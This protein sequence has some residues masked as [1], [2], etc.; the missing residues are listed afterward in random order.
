MQEKNNVKIKLPKLIKENPV[1][2]A[3]ISKLNK[4]TR[5]NNI[6]PQNSNIQAISTSINEKIKSNE[7]IVQLFPDT[8][9]C[10][11]ILTSSIISPN[12]M[13]SNKLKYKA[14]DIKLPT[15]IKDTILQEIENYIEKN[16]DLNSKLSIILRES[17]FTKGAYIEA[18]IPE[19]SLDDIISQYQ[20]K[21]NNAA[22]NTK[23]SFE[24]FNTKMFNPT[25]DFLSKNDTSYNLFPTVSNEDNKSFTLNFSTDAATDNNVFKITQEDLNIEIT[26]NFKVLN[27]SEFLINNIENTTKAKLH[28]LNMSREDELELDKW[29]KPAGNFIY[30]DYLEV[31]TMDGS[32]RESYGKPLVFKLPVESVIPVHVMNNPS[33]HLGYFVMLDNNGIPVI[34]NLNTTEN[35]EYT[36]FININNDSKLNLIQ[37]AKAGLLGMTKKEP[38]LSNIEEMYSSI[39]EKM[40]KNK[41]KNGLFG[42]LVDMKDNYD[43]Y[44][45]MFNRALHNQQTKILFLP[46]ELVAF[47]AFD[48]RENGTGKSLLEKSSVLYSIRAI[49]LFSRIMAYLKNS[50]TITEVNTVIDEKDPNPDSTMEMIKSETLKLR[51]AALPLGITAVNDLQEWASMSGIRYKF[52]HP[53]LPT[54]EINT[55]DMS[56]SK[57]IPDDELDRIIKE[58]IIMSF[59]LTPEIVEAGYNSDFATTVTAKNLLLAKRTTQMQNIFLPQIC[60]HIRK[61]LVNDK[62]VINKINSIVSNNLTEIKRNLNKDKNNEE[63]IKFDKIGKNKLIEYITEKFINEV[64]VLLP[65]PETQEANNIKQAFE[66]YESTLT[67]VMDL[68]FST[69]S[70]PSE[71]AG[72][73]SN[74]TDQLKSMFKTVLIKSWISNNNYLPELSQFLTKDDDGKPTFDIL[75]DYTSFLDSVSEAFIPFMKTRTKKVSKLNEKIS[76]ATDASGND[77]YGSYDDGDNDNANDADDDYGDDDNLD[78]NDEFGEEGDDLDAEG[79]MD[80]EPGDMGS[81][82]NMDLG[83]D[84][85]DDMGLD[86]SSNDKPAEG[87]SETDIKL[88]EA[89]IE[90]EKARA[91]KERATAELQ[92]AK[93]KELED[94]TNNDD[95]LDNYDDTLPDNTINDS[96]NDSDAN[97][98]ND[99]SDRGTVE[100]QTNEENKIKIPNYTTPYT[101]N[102]T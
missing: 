74:F 80:D 18:I 68:M 23:L 50:T 19:S 79:N 1:A 46:S 97:I 57:T 66:D 72:D 89:K 93:A 3:L 69:E 16:Y 39:V 55:S 81:D 70:F 64:E 33:K 35:T 43:I 75:S 13:I 52:Q 12:D 67:T 38:I 24:Q 36:D 92:R 88:K 49:L 17:L 40:L 60:E 96:D 73:I 22:Q 45:I 65:K 47:Y 2:A 62:T 101:S 53:G 28:T 25:Y 102:I 71:F 84:F 87:E 83:D 61:L 54:T 30:K 95:S 76:K 5:T 42:D 94:E 20:F 29:F 6:T 14:P 41:L 4:D 99:D 51:Q 8:E 10:I 98:V 78:N 34:G 7:D 56:T 27:F 15:T 58:Y 91:E 44:R 11:Q 31:N 37:K 85:G 59:G 9:L 48:Y 32:S 21:N 63:N 82:E 26:D 90:T 86:D 77:D 100:Q